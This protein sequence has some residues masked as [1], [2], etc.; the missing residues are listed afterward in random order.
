MR[1]FQLP[2]RSPAMAMNGMAATH[3]PHATRTAVEVLRSGGS[4]I[5]AA[6]AAAALLATSYNS[7]MVHSLRH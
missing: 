5:D 2:G 3:N 6:V 4:A 7:P 1:D